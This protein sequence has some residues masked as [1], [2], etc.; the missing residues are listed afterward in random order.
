MTDEWLACLDNKKLVGTVLLDFTAAF[1]VIE[2]DILVAK[3][4]CYGFSCTALDWIGSYLSNRKQ[5]VFYN[6]SFS[7]TKNTF[8][9]V[10]GS[11]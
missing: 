6:G 8:C 4:K 3:L 9:S 2:H 7:E 10:P 11:C 5:N 1:D